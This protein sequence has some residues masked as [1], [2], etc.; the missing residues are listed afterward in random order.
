MQS[1]RESKEFSQ[2]ETLYMMEHIL[3]IVNG[4]CREV[5]SQE[6]MYR[7]A[8]TE[9]DQQIAHL[10]KRR[11]E[12]L[13]AKRQCDFILRLRK[14]G[15]EAWKALS[16]RNKWKKE[17]ILAVFCCPSDKLPRS[18]TEEFWSERAPEALRDDR[19][20]FI[21]RCI[22][23]MRQF[24]QESSTRD[25]LWLQPP[26]V[27]PEALL[28]DTR[29]IAIATECHPQVI[30]QQNL[31]PNVLDDDSVFHGFL[32]S[33]RRRHFYSTY[34]LSHWKKDAMGRFSIRIR[35]NPELVLQAA[36]HGLNVLEHIAGQLC[37][38]L[39]FATSIAQMAGAIPD[40]ALEHSSE[41]LRSNVHMGPQ[42][43][44]SLMFAASIIQRKN[45]IPNNALE[46]LSERLRS[47][48]DFVLIV[49]KKN[50]LCL[51]HAADSLRD[52]WDIVTTA[53][54]NEP[55]ALQ[56]C[57]P[58]GKVQ[59]SLGADRTFMKNFFRRCPILKKKTDSSLQAL[60]DEMLSPELKRDLEI[61]VGARRCNAL[62]VSNLSS[63]LLSNPDVW[64][65]LIKQSSLFW[66]DLPEKFKNDILFVRC[67]NY[68]EESDLGL[69]KEIIRR[70]PELAADKS[71]WTMVIE[72]DFGY[73][74]L[75]EYL[76]PDVATKE[77][78][79]DK[80]M[81]IKACITDSSVLSVLDDNLR[82]DR[83]II[84]AAVNNCTHACYHFPVE[85]QLL[86]PGLTAKA[87]ENF[88]EAENV[89]IL[90]D[91]AEEL[92]G[93]IHV[94]CT[95]FQVG[96][97][98]HDLIPLEM[99]ENSQVG[100]TIAET[101]LE[102]FE[103][104]VSYSLRSNK[105][106]MIQAVQKNCL[107]YIFAEGGLLTDD[108]V[109]LAAFASEGAKGLVNHFCTANEAGRCSELLYMN[110]LLQR[111]CQKLDLFD[112]FIKCVLCGISKHAGPSSSLRILDCGKETATAIQKLIAEY[113]GVPMNEELAILRKAY[114]NLK[115]LPSP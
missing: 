13:A 75:S 61:I 40:N 68:I 37:N 89:N 76:F 20:I 9:L 74:D 15:G 54:E 107:V 46:H 84:E 82:L 29:V 25:D 70:F 104:H 94:L 6:A 36:K 57:L 51:R 78:L 47:N 34:S 55:L 80:S 59:R 95:W 85:A 97:E 49:V 8:I 71:F 110:Q 35:S 77:I 103:N 64:V 31:K 73:E 4:V 7:T 43:Y 113:A 111:V 109:T 108:D 22:M 100:L 66:H 26:L 102:I 87:I 65:A 41:P 83:D 115:A 2:E 44:N 33:P 27:V 79:S 3:Q 12:F 17:H 63:E 14:D 101:D 39:M 105:N 56:Y 48:F 50:G 53:V 67:I 69:V 28:G 5:S 16:N 60:I 30:F 21:A 18:L 90:D 81:M 93:N 86:Y 24:Q 99:F 11:K 106:F 114:P 52:D 62:N 19:D 92:W 23:Q 98:S 88:A 58:G 42:V 112:A 72:S 32:K 91:I 38:D 1:K 96:G 45:A 10:Q